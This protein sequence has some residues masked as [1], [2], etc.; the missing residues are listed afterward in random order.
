MFRRVRSTAPVA[1]LAA[2]LTIAV[3]SSKAYAQDDAP[4]AAGASAG[5][6]APPVAAEPKGSAPSVSMALERVGGVSYS[7]VSGDK[8]SDGSGSLFALGIGSVNVNPYTAPRLG[9]DYILPIGL[10][11]GGGLG[12][13]H[14]SLSAKGSDGKSQGLGSLS[15]YTLTPRV[16]YRV[17][18]S[19]R[20]DLVPRAGVTLAG[21]SVSSNDGRDSSG[22]F[23][24]ALSAEGAGVLRLTSSFNL[25]AGVG[26]DQTVA[27]TASSSTTTSSGGTRSASSDIKG[28]LFSA[29]LWLGMGGYL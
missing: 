6:G 26:I 5:T 17:A 8:S 16:G 18:L 7:S 4:P 25:L 23:A 20:F 29:Q 10:T 15:L 27:A 2:S 22:V 28:S 11:L 12:F 24:L 14:F 13:G 9:I 3:D 21:G 19:D 1:I